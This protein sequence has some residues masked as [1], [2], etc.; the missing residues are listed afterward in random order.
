MPVR[1]R[2]PSNVLSRVVKVVAGVVLGLLRM[3]I[4]GALFLLLA[5][6][7]LLAKLVRQPRR[8]TFHLCR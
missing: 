4:I 3:P 7:S 5:V 8:T 6:A 2:W 1:R